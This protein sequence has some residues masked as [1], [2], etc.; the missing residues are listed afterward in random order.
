MR[1]MTEAERLW[2]SWYDAFLEV[3]EALPERADVRCPEGDGG[4]VHLTYYAQPGMRV[5][6]ATVWCDVGRNGIF[7]DRV[8]VPEGADVLPFGAAPEQRSG[9]IPEG[10]TLIPTAMY[11]R[12]G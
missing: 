4:R 10:I 6:S 2:E 8:G 3:L 1:E 12:E 7:L 11:D 9:V 5:G